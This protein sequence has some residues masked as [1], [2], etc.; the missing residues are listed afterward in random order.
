MN[1]KV[2]LGIFAL[3]I[4]AVCSGLSFLADHFYCHTKA[5][6]KLAFLQRL[7]LQ[8]N[9]VKRFL[10]ENLKFPKFLPSFLVDG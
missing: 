1:L 6:T 4:A 3:N 7:A 5:L 2:F 10:E 8:S 9:S